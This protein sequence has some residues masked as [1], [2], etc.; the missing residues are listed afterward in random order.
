MRKVIVITVMLTAMIMS[1]C[2]A[3]INTA[4]IDNFNSMNNPQGKFE[5]KKSVEV[6]I[7]LFQLVGVEKTQEI[8]QGFFVPLVFTISPRLLGEWDLGRLRWDGHGFNPDKT[9]FIFQVML[10]KVNYSGEIMGVALIP[11]NANAK[12]KLILPS[13]GLSVGYDLKGKEFEIDFLKFTTLQ[14]YRRK[15]VEKYGTEVTTL[16]PAPFNM[17]EVLKSW[18]EYRTSDGKIILSPLGSEDMKLVASINP[19]QTYGD[20]FMGTSS[21]TITASPIGMAQSWLVDAIRAG[22]APTLG[23]DYASM[24]TRRKMGLLAELIARMF[25]KAM[26]EMNTA[27]KSLFGEL[28]KA[29]EKAVS[30]CTIQKESAVSV[31]IKTT[32]VATDKRTP[33]NK[34]R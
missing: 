3:G 25:K 32:S 8:E 7:E 9:E 24:V 11:G 2:A 18:N 27:N 28:V 13:T 20:K 10:W 31:P 30:Q 29:E 26:A 16:K 14:E 23:S 1:G 12:A 17:V 33:I 34:R 5:E 21:F 22:G 6:P 15:T 4:K 19:Q